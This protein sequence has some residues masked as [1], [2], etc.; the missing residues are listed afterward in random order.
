[1]DFIIR[2]VSTCVC[3]AFY[4]LVYVYPQISHYAA[5]VISSRLLYL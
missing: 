4:I 1:M 2:P 5:C 3:A